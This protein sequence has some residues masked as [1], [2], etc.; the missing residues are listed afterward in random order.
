M[1]SDHGRGNHTTVKLRHHPL[2]YYSGLPS[3]PPL[4]VR[5]DDISK[6]PIQSDEIGTLAQVRFD[7]FSSCKIMLRMQEGETQ[8]AA[9]LMFDDQEFCVRVYQAVKYLVGKPVKE[10]GEIEIE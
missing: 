2:V 5:T 3:W 4:W 10:L 9:V 1:E 8:Y 6:R 7:D